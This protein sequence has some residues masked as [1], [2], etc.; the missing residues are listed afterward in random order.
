MPRKP[1]LMFQISQ[2]VSQGLGRSATAEAPIKGSDCWVSRFTDA[3]SPGQIGVKNCLPRKDAECADLHGKQECLW[4]G[5]H[6]CPSPRSSV[7]S[8]VFRGKL[9]LS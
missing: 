4:L 7:S 1:K 2:N 6:N 3:Q 8:V 9:L 5:S